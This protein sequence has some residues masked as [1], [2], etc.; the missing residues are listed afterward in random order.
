MLSKPSRD[1]LFKIFTNG[2]SVDGQSILSSAE[3]PGEAR[4]E[5]EGEAILMEWAPDGI[6][7]LQRVVIIESNKFVH[8]P[9]QWYLV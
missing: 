1:N 7:L 5:G 4:G 3:N 6:A 9:S 2:L 8:R